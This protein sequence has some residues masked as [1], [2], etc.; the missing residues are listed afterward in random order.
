MLTVTMWDAPCDR[1]G[2]QTSELRPFKLSE[3]IT[4]REKEILHPWLCLNCF[5]IEKLKWWEARDARD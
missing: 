4:F 2:Q 1:C 5:K 3:V